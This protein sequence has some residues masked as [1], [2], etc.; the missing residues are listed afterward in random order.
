M[1]H[2]F[3][4]FRG[5]RSS[6]YHCLRCGHE[7]LRPSDKG[8]PTRCARCKSPYWRTEKRERAAPASSADE[9]GAPS[10]YEGLQLLVFNLA[11]GA[12][13]VN[14]AAVREVVRMPA[15]TVIPGTPDHVPGVISLRGR[16][17]PVVDLRRKLGLVAAEETE[18]SRI[19]VAQ[20][21]GQQV[22]MVVDAVAAVL[23][24]PGDSVQPPPALLVTDESPYT[25]GIVKHE[26]Q[27]I[28]L[29]DVDRVLSEAMNAR[30]GE[31]P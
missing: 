7:W 31:G 28:V 10:L 19:V 20:R 25:L 6:V 18:D 1:E 3:V 15:I 12:Y 2:P 16:V 9:G 23:R 11:D 4:L 26:G 14:I 27:L 29:L 30:P 17:V 13:G 24:V 21:D 5:E 8:L 22:G